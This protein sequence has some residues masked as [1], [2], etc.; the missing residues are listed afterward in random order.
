VK[1]LRV[2]LP[3]GNVLEVTD[4]A[5]S[6]EVVAQIGP[7]LSKAAIAAT[8]TV[9]GISEVCD[10]ARPLPGDCQ[11][12]VLT[13]KDDHPESLRILR[14]S[15]A[16]VMAEAV[17]NLFPKAELV[18]GPPLEDG[19]YYDL[20]LDRSL[21]SDDFEA[22]EAEMRRIV[23]ED[24]PFRRYEL[25]RDQAMDKLQVE[26]NRY[27]I[28]NAERAEGDTIS[29]YVTGEEPGQSFEDLCRGPHVP[30]TGRIGA[31]KVRQV[32][33]SHY[34]GDVN[35]Q[36]LQRVY[37]TAFFKPKSLKVFLEQLEQAKKR[38]HRLIG[39]ELDIFSISLEVGSGLVLW[40]PQGAVV[41]MLLENFMRGELILRGYKPVYT[42]HIARLDLFRTSGHYPYYEDSQFP[43]MHETDR[44]R[45][46]FS[47][48]HLTQRAA[49]HTTDRREASMQPVRKL[50][51]AVLDI[52]GPIE[53]FQS[54][55]SPERMIEI[56][57]RELVSE[58]GY[59]LKPMNCPHHI[60]IY[61]SQPRSY[62]D[63]PIRLAEFGTVHRYEQSGELGG[64]VRV[65]GFTQDDA[66]LFCTP[67]QLEEELR[68]TV[69]LTQLVLTTLDFTGYRVRLGLR[70]PS[71]TKWVGVPEQWD[72]AENNIRSVVRELGLEHSEEAGE[73]TFYGPKIDFLVR[74]CL[75]REWQLGTVQVDYTL[76]ERF[77]LNYIGS[78]N[79]PHR[80]IMIHRAPFGSMERFVGILIEHFAGAFPLWL[81]PM[82]VGVVSISDKSAD[83]ARQVYEQCLSFG[84]RAQ[85]DVSADKIGPKKH[86]LRG[87][88]VPYILVV[89][90][91]EAQGQTVNVNDRDGKTMGTYPVGNFLEGC[92]VEIETKGHAAQEA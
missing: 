4:G 16:H 11:L 39:R 69:E 2:T 55:A 79:Q 61:K 86:R 15:A 7:G 26:G 91:Q 33:R 28:D 75:G 52:W 56:L 36:P 25:P 92:R 13:A 6:S 44:G 38:D 54:D 12:S 71:S 1:P 72:L 18:Y 30:S 84:L 65:R 8:V 17:C 51:Q 50:A 48:L 53:G 62:R 21:S 80:P 47:L 90:E 19:F 57:Q 58:D 29:F 85:L 14:H 49:K 43:P 81:A 60:H 89:G 20:D 45:T 46:L 23:D 42:P 77:D 82:Q 73:A 3:D 78:D 34:R 32:S 70:D 40:H 76:P 63:L 27:K 35:D 10:L 59:L 41:R 64:M 22:I 9:D 31:F 88:R 5:T 87:Q 66:H 68:I 37:G 83:Y 67:E 74:D 24:R